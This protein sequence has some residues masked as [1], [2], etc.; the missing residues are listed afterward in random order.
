MAA[1]GLQIVLICFPIIGFQMVAGNFFQSI[2]MA[3]KAIFLS[4]TRQ[5]I[6]L[7][8]FLLLL[9][10]FLG[11]KGIW[12]SMPSADFAASLVSAFMLRAQ[13]RTFK[14]KSVTI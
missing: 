2:G 13:F 11:V 1:E 14:Q 5:L 6:F 12:Y 7:L 10:H 9:P 4:L 8:P 3:H